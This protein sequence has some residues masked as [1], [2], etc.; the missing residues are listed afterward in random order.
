MATIH[1]LFRL[2]ALARH[3]DGNEQTQDLHGTF[4]TTAAHVKVIILVV[5]GQKW[6]GLGSSSFVELG[7]F[8]GKSGGG[9]LQPHLRVRLNTEMMREGG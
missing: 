5:S 8:S 4:L 3:A 6:L 9:R 2:K 1:N 7:A